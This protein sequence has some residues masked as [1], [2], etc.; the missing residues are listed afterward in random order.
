MIAAFLY[1][2]SEL[3]PVGLL[4]L[5]AD[6]LG[7]SP[8]AIGLLVTGYALAV[9]V[10]SIPLTHVTRNLPR[11]QV[12]AA[13]LTVFV[14][15]T[16]ATAATSSYPVLLAARIASALTQ[17]LFWSLATPTAMALFPRRIRGRVSAT[18]TAGGGLAAVLG[19]PAGTWLGLASNWRVAFY[20][21][22]AFGLLALITVVVL[23]PPTRPAGEEHGAN[24]DRPD[25]RGFLVMLAVTA[26]A[27]T[28]QFAALTYITEFLIEVS[29]YSDSAVSALL[30]AR[31]VAGVG[32]TIAIGL[33]Q[34]RRPRLALLGT[35]ALQAVSIGLL[36]P[37][38]ESKAATL[39]L[40]ALSGL[41]AGALPAA[42]ATQAM[43]T[44]PGSTDLASAG[45]SSAFNV[46]IA[47]GAL[48][49]GALL[50]LLGVRST[51]L[52]GG[53]LTLVAVVLVLAEPRATPPP[54]MVRSVTQRGVARGDE[55]LPARCGER[56]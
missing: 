13:L 38:G 26:L 24:A 6:D 34:D 49:G 55:S 9:A 22:A 20:T 3:L 32:G 15:A 1:V 31:G 45:T 4:G 29:G 10:T 56:A 19:I 2:T 11:R 47:S 48:I 37:F 14:V 42:F 44:A 8:S 16:V 33:V 41:A 23:L 43:R 18:L 52:A 39:A 53:L 50:P 30:L 54:V 35:I 5:M 46:G 17:A 40:L 7:T 36:Y 12:F 27:I 21:L 25:R 51:A 28:G